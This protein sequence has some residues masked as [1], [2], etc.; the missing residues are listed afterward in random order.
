MESNKL[1]VVRRGI[2]EHCRV[3]VFLKTLAGRIAEFR[4]QEMFL[5]MFPKYPG[6]MKVSSKG[7]SLR[8]IGVPFKDKF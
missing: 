1:I 5:E 2:I 6:E 7:F 8:E 4:E 3:G